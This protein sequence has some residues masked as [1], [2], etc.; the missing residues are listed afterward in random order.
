[1]PRFDIGPI[2]FWVSPTT[3][4]KSAIA[5]ANWQ[6]RGSQEMLQEYR[7]FRNDF[8]PFLL[9][10]PHDQ[11]LD[12]FCMV[13]VEAIKQTIHRYNVSDPT[14]LA[15]ASTLTETLE[16][17]E[18]HTAAID[19][20][21][22]YTD[23]MQQFQASPAGDIAR[24]AA[25]QLVSWGVQPLYEAVAGAGSLGNQVYGQYAPAMRAICVQMKVVCQDTHADICFIETLLHEQIHA[26]IFHQMGDDAERREL[27]WLH[28][29]AALL[30]SQAAIRT[31]VQELPDPHQVTRVVRILNDLR[32]RQ[33]F[34][35]L[36]DAVLKD[37][38]HPLVAW[39]AWKQ[40]FQLSPDQQRNYATCE[41]ITPILH[42]YGWNVHFPYHYGDYF[43]SCFVDSL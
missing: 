8:F 18:N 43:V 5:L 42:R 4:M 36:A 33:D 41:I 19:Y 37:T 29:L 27:G 28:E 21:R 6:A 30:T 20:T 39:L 1:M 14:V 12:E 35:D 38:S 3:I 25:K 2:A 26:A 23:W 31:A 10:Q 15:F 32:T 13:A 11:P 16:S 34:G 22:Q 24:R 40:V 7:Q 17:P 9:S